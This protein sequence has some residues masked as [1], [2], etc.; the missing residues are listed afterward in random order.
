[1]PGQGRHWQQQ[2]PESKASTLLLPLR[3]EQGGR[4][5]L[6]VRE[7]GVSRAGR[8]ELSMC[9]AGPGKCGVAALVN[10]REPQLL[11]KTESLGIF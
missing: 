11:P 3:K 4:S 10:E 1:M 6:S 8:R 7:E 2:L 9:A 5:D